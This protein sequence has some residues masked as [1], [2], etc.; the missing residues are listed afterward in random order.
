MRLNADQPQPY[1]PR[2]AFYF[3]L[4]CLMLLLGL[5]GVVVPLMP[6]TIFLILAAWAFGRSS[7]RLENWM[8]DHPRFGPA[9]RNWR[10]HGA[11]SRHAKLMACGG[12]AV[13][14]GLFLA[15]A[16]P[17]IW[18]ALAVALPMLACAAWIIARPE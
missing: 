16:R 1:S 4:G 18:L 12:M 5:I 17:Q 9:L 3:A 15:G 14:Y 8:L 7:T 13:G 11:M 10:E 2:R 6:T